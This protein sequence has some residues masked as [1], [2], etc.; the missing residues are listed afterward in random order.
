LFFVPDIDRMLDVNRLGAAA[1]ELRAAAARGDLRVLGVLADRALGKWPPDD[2]PDH[3]LVFLEPAGI[4]E[5]VALLSSRRADLLPRSSAGLDVTVT[6]AA[7]EAAARLADRYFRDPPP[8]AGALRLL[9]DAATAIKLHSVDGMEALRDGRVAPSPSVDPD[10]VA[11]ALERLTGIRANLDDRERLLAMEA[12]LASRVVGQ[13]HAIAVVTDAVR[14]AR[15]GLKDA[16]RP[17]GSFLFLGP[18]G[19]GKT[20][21]AKALAEFLFDDEQAMV[22]LDMSEYQERHTVSRLLGAPPGYVGFDQGGQLTE[23]VRR[24][25]YQLVLFDEIEKAHPDIHNVLLQIMDDGRLTD[26]RGRTV[27]FRHTLVIMTGNV[28][29]DFYRLEEELGREKVEAAVREEARSVFRPEFLGRL[30]EL[31][32]FRRLGPESMRLIVDI[33]EKKLAKKL[34][35]QGIELTF[36]PALKDAL[37]ETGYAPELGARPLRNEIA[38]RVERPLSKAIIEGTVT[39]GSRVVA[40]LAAGGAVQ[41]KNE[42]E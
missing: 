29:S 9:R 28:G 31:L 17:I 21:L 37:A 3:E 27:D 20:E 18:S 32:V 34:R 2:G 13:D 40:E 4:E 42:A 19:V 10:D 8:P 5:T 39:R 15:A 14:R 11:F 35:E 41:F 23:P 1:G 24:K 7:I 25:P 26:A 22:R 30:D 6:D 36:S 12:S 16:N 33:H 38:N